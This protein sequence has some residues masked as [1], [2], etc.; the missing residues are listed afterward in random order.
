MLKMGRYSTVYCYIQ[1]TLSLYA[2]PPEGALGYEADC[3][4]CDDVFFIHTK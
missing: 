4:N 3:Y 1:G 2:F